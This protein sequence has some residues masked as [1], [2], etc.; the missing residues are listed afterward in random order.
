MLA[1]DRVLYAPDE[2]IGD[3]ICDWMADGRSLCEIEA[4]LLRLAPPAASFDE[5]DARQ[6]PPWTQPAYYVD[7]LDDISVGTTEPA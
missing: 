1:A 2:G 6:N 7:R 5:L 4:E 3:S